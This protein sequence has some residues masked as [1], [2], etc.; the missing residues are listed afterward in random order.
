MSLILTDAASKQAQKT[1][2]EPQLVL[3]I[4]GFETVFCV[5]DLF[6]YIRIG[7]PE[8][9]I[10]D[11]WV[12][13]G[14]NLVDAQEDLI[15][16]EGTGT[17]I[18]QQ[19]RPDQGSVSSVSAITVAIVDK[20]N[21]A[22][23]LISPGVFVEDILGRRANVWMGFKTSAFKE[24]YIKIFSGAIDDIVSDAGLVKLTVS[25]ADQKKRQAIFIKKDAVLASTINSSVTTLSFI[26]SS[27]DFDVGMVGPDSTI[28]PTLRFYVKIDNEV[29]EYIGATTSTLTSCVRGALGTNATAHTG[30]AKIESIYVLEGD[31]IYLALK[32]MMSGTPG[33]YISGIELE[34]FNVIDPFLSIPNTIF[35][36]EVNI[37]EEYG[38]VEGDFIT[39]TGATFGANNVTLKKISSIIQ[40]NDG[41]YIRISGVTF[42]NEPDSAAVI[43]FTSQFNTLPIGLSMDPRDVDVEEHIYWRN[44]FLNDFKYRFYFKEDQNGKDLIEKQFYFPSGAYSIPRKAKASVGYHLGPLARDQT[45]VLSKNEITK[46]GKISLRRTTARQFANTIIYSYD[47][48][49][50]ENRNLSGQIYIS[51]TSQNR[52]PVG[53]KAIKIVSQGIRTDLSGKQKTKFA[54]ERMLSRYKYGAEYIEKLGVT[55]RDGFNVEVGDIVILDPEGLSISNTNA[56]DRNRPSKLYEVINNS[57]DI[58]TGEVTVDIVDT[59]Y[60]LEERFGTISPSSKIVSG[61]TSYA[62]IE[63]SYNA[64]FPGNEKKKWE[65]YLSL[66]IVVRN[67]TYTVYEQTILFGFDPVDP[68]KMLFTTPLSFSVVA[69]YIIDVPDYPSDSDPKTND[70]YKAVHAFLSPEVTVVSGIDNFSFTVGAGDVAKFQVGFPVSVH[71]ANF[72][73]SSEELRVSIVAGVTITVSADLGFTPAAGQKVSFLGFPDAN[74]C[75]RYI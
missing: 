7:D 21:F 10:G 14:L 8:L 28:D 49:I 24:D 70:T 46:P 61:T 63:D 39:T 2:I 1:G 59:N 62:I 60:G 22:T 38:I 55:F 13:G 6:K 40:T 9:Y 30:G 75:Y 72:S 27:D 19:L 15:S 37:S 44:L 3:E 4:D 64:I 74:H 16:F 48:D 67:E 52:I 17:K 33:P 29:I 26:N 68:Y 51:A 47:Q 11:E 73:I 53:T 35:F 45:Q 18:Q 56:G 31:M 65:K 50:L 34:N 41:S 25:H 54:A 42:V 36:K 12:I 66:P 69:G 5:V 20:D 32:T 71:N 58:K 43:S 23:K 57:V